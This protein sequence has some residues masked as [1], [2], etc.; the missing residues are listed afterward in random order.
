MKKS[1]LFLFCIFICVEPLFAQGGMM[2]RRNRNLI[3]NSKAVIVGF[4]G[5]VDLAG[6]SYTSSELKSLSQ[7]MY[8]RPAAGLFVEFPL[9]KSFAVGAD[10]LY[11]GRGVKVNYYN[12]GDERY[13]VNY[14]ISSNYFD[15]RIPL[16]YR[17]LTEKMLNPYVFLAPDFSMLTGGT[18]SLDQS[19]IFPARRK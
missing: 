1:I 8:L 16:T 13:P 4:K 2:Q 5:G 12:G 11:Q 6:M 7:D 14:Q 10:F 19:R 9:S 3:T 18:I 17:F 15:L